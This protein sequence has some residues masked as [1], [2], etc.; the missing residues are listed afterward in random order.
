MLTTSSSQ[1]F[2]PETGIKFDLINLSAVW[3]EQ[4]DN[5]SNYRSQDKEQK[6]FQASDPKR[7]RE[8]NQEEKMAGER[9]CND[10]SLGHQIKSRV[11]FPS[12]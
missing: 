6:A 2:S 10:K 11:F 4:K 3:R 1:S 5:I 8:S 12:S 7:V 9:D